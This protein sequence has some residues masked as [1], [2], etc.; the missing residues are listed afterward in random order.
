M[1]SQS[2][3]VAKPAASTMRLVLLALLLASLVPT[4]ASGAYWSIQNTPTPG[5]SLYM[6]DLA[7]VSCVSATVCTAVGS[8]DNPSLGQ[9]A[10]AERWDGRRWTVQATP[11]PAG[12]DISMLTDVS[13]VSAV[14]CLAV[15]N[16][17]NGRFLFG[18]FAERWNGTRWVLESVPNPGPIDT[19][20]FG[21]SCASATACV[22]V[23]TSWTSVAL[24]E[25]WDGSGWTVQPTPNL[26]SG[27]TGTLEAVACVSA[28]ACFAVGSRSG[29]GGTTT[30]LAERWD[31]TQWSVQPTPSPSGA[32][33]TSTLQ[34]VSCTSATACTAVGGYERAGAAGLFAERWDGTRWS[35][36]VMPRSLGAAG[37]AGVS[38]VS[39]HA[40]VAVTSGGTMPLAVRW[41]GKRWTVETLPTQGYAIENLNGLACVSANVC[42][43]VGNF[44]ISGQQRTLVF[45]SSAPLPARAKL[46]G[47]PV[48]CVRSRF[49]ARVVGTAIA[50]V[51]WSL[52]R[53]LI[54]G[55]AV[56]R[57]TLYAAVIRP[58]P[59]RHRL[60]V[61]VTFKAAAQT[62]P[63]TF[64]RFVVSCRR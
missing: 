63:R 57:G 27:N 40:C 33:V 52:D 5:G 35:L 60:A 22:A 25:R 26:G 64:R 42:S 7:A 55:R 10:L 56:Y 46:T 47:I 50:S 18:A 9:V 15:G 34:A 54:R 2:V 45:R 53:R 30:T 16:Y 32:R 17:G 59:R 43:A 37:F 11:D 20:L 19:N 61:T 51:K 49:T 62:H 29:A 31:G 21:V 6:S 13:C 58:G 8:R 24:A 14:S 3:P 38:C 12:S 39:A 44:S 36:Q 48:G 28:S 1:S 4:A 41:D 23:G